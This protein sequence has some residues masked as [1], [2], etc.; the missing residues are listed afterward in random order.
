MRAGACS[1]QLSGG[2]PT[3][4]EDLPEVVALGVK[5]GFFFIQVNTNGILNRRQARLREGAARSGPFH[6]FPPV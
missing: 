1:I 2:E 4:R 5:K 3:L 6:R